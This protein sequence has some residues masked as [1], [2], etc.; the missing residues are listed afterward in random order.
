VVETTPAIEVTSISEAALAIEVIFIPEPT[1]R[2]AASVKARASIETMEPRAG[3][4]KYVACKPIRSVVT[5]RR[6]RVRV[7]W[8]VAIG[9]YGWWTI[10][11]RAADPNADHNPLCVCKR[12]RTQANAKYGENS[13]ISHMGSLLR[14]PEPS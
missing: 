8:I 10:V 7:I 3:A 1:P 4:D 14:V 2:V 6:A 12:R 9:A 5:I 13:Q 11:G